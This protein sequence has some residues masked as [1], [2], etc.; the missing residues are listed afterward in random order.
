MS[1]KV[2]CPNGHALQV[3]GE[4]AGK[5]GLCPHC[6]A[7][8]V[9]PQAEPQAVS[10]DDLLEVLGPPRV[11]PR[12]P[13]P[14]APPPPHRP[15]APKEEPKKA[16]A[17]STGAALLR[18]QKVCPKCCEILAVV[19]TDCPRCRTPLTEWTFPLPEEDAAQQRSRSACRYVGVRKQGD[20]FVIRFGEHRILDELIIKKFADEL[21]QVAERPD[22]HNVLLNFVGVVGLSSGMLGI[23]LMLHKKMGLKAGTVKLCQVGPEIMDVFHA[24]KLGQL[25]EILTSEY[26]GL[27]A[28][29]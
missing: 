27:E 19:H 14:S 10:E 5:S 22:C 28:F 8:I 17:A 25:F 6:K 3:K 24:T 29:A 11:V 26:E 18:R 13:A 21:F 2:I 20:V 1:I 12:M 23:M 15:A 9:V 4:F 7:L 16:P